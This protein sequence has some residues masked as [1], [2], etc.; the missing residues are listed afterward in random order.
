MEAECP[1]ETSEAVYPTMQ[2]QGSEE[3]KDRLQRHKTAKTWEFDTVYKIL[4][5][6]K[7]SGTSD[8]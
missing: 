7:F 4:R 8:Q 3:R 6:Q 2:F 1:F 5:Q